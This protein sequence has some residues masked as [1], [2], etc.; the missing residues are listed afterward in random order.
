[1]PGRLI[2]PPSG[3]GEHLN[4]RQE[5][6]GEPLHSRMN[7][8]GMNSGFTTLPAPAHVSL[9]SLLPLL[10]LFVF[11]IG[12]RACAN[13]AVVATPRITLIVFTD[14]HMPEEEWEALSRDLQQEYSLLAAETHFSPGAFDLIRGDTLVPGIEVESPIT[15]YLHGECTLLARPG[16]SV[17]QGALGWVL[18]SHGRIEPFIH[19][20]C[21]R[22]GEM[23]GNYAQAMNYDLRNN[24]MA[25][26]IARI[27]VHEWIHLA[28]QSPAHKQ[29]G[30]SRS[31]FS[32]ADLIPSF[33][34]QVAGTSR[35]R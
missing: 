33:W 27:V 6:G 5:T 25:E 19:V 8:G 30:V 23:L 11:W 21:S 10:V 26:A 29:D 17:T 1:M 24:V 18:R 16:L 14:K 3:S 34:P 4:C 9:R 28:T 13:A 31:T 32:V 12:G 22:I 15:I 20:D 35:G 7:I 2:R